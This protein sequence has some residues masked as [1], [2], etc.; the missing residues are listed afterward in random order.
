[1][2]ENDKQE[3]HSIFE[4]TPEE[5]ERAEAAQKAQQSKSEDEQLKAMLEADAKKVDLRSPEEKA[6]E[7]ATRQQMADEQRR[8]E[9]LTGNTRPEAEARAAANEP[10]PVMPKEEP[11][12]T[13]KNFRAE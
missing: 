5:K 13:L 2:N 3:P 4:Q 7:A 10:P 6:R 11:A 1:M 9:E 8:R 12:Q